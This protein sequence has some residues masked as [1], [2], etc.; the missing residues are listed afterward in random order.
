MLFLA[1]IV[2]VFGQIIGGP[3]LFAWPVKVAP[4]VAQGR[5]VGL[6]NGVFWVGQSLGPA[7][8][9]LLYQRSAAPSGTSA[10]SSGCCRRR[11]PGS[12]C[13]SRAR[14]PRT[15]RSSDEVEPAAG[16][17]VPPLGPEVEGASERQRPAPSLTSP[18]D[19][20]GRPCPPAD[21]A[22]CLGEERTMTSPTG[23]VLVVGYT[24]AMQ[25]A[26]DKFMPDDSC[27]FVDEPT[28]ARKRDAAQHVSR[29]AGHHRRDRVGVPAAPAR[30]T[31][32]STR[33]R[34]WRR[35]AVLPGVEYAVPFAARLAERYGVPGADLRRRRGAAG[36]APAPAGQR[37]GRDPQPALGPGGRAR[38]RSASGW[39]SG[40]RSCSSRRTGRRRSAPGCCPT[41]A[42]VDA[43]WADCTDQDEGIYQPDRG[44]EPC[45]CWSRSTSAAPS[46]ASS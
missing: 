23:P 5:Y 32:S 40:A 45:G 35:S 24:M 28:V 26:L 37:R 15:C 1:T 27:A 8:G 21:P 14:A 2:G 16:P 19:P 6:G 39:P 12:A 18:D 46:S 10:A 42:G 44:I 22:R 30:R 25:K 7:L 31:G 11:P 20:R 17:A 29:G 13:G 9:L 43:A 4:P 38:P 33:T 3:T 41:P 34:T 36:Q